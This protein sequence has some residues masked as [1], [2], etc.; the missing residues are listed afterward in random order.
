MRAET[1]IDR[2]VKRLGRNS[3]GRAAIL[4]TI[5]TMELMADLKGHTK[6]FISAKALSKKTSFSEKHVQTLLKDLRDEGLVIKNDDG[7]GGRVKK[8]GTSGTVGKAAARSLNWEKLISYLQDVAAQAPSNGAATKDLNELRRL[9]VDL[10]I[11]IEK[12]RK[13]A[14]PKDTENAEK[15]APATT[16]NQVV[17]TTRNRTIPTTGNQAPPVGCNPEDP[18]N[19]KDLGTS[20]GGLPTQEQKTH[21]ATREKR[22]G[23][24]QLSTNLDDEASHTPASAN[25]PSKPPIQSAQAQSRLGRQTDAAKPYGALEK[26]VLDDDSKLTFPEY[27]AKYAPTG[28][29]PHTI[30]AKAK[31]LGILP[32]TQSGAADLT[33]LPT[34]APGCPTLGERCTT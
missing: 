5:A 22:V 12:T 33:A 29:T 8:P 2:S 7:K 34:N 17:A 18:G 15:N 30:R 6:T 16:G 10:Q 28:Q 21:V 23:S 20:L 4:S 32:A 3:K 13:P 19:P 25:Q 1:L 26:S 11:R 14:S 31:R 9:L 24:I 27:Y